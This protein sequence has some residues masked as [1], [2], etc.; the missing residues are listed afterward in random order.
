VCAHVYFSFFLLLVT[1]ELCK[2]CV[3][4]RTTLISLTKCWMRLFQFWILFLVMDDSHIRNRKS[5]FFPESKKNRNLDFITSLCIDFYWRGIHL[6][7]MVITWRHFGI[8]E[9]VAVTNNRILRASLQIRHLLTGRTTQGD[10][11]TIMLRHPPCARPMWSTMRERLEGRE[12][13]DCN[14]IP[15]SPWYQDCRHSTGS[16]PPATDDA[17]PPPPA[18]S[19]DNSQLSIT[20][21]FLRIRLSLKLT[22]RASWF[23]TNGRNINNILSTNVS[24][25]QTGP[26]LVGKK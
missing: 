11:R 15:A 10:Q 22:K 17:T 8:P 26:K 25:N 21:T 9:I 18:G 19:D 12:E 23:V 5:R 13:G 4:S 7:K 14:L 2:E 1:A 16:W 24:I 6:Y 3:K 20:L